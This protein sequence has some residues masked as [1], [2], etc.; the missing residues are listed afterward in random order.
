VRSTDN[1]KFLFDC[2]DHTI[3]K[4]IPAEVSYLEKFDQMK[5]WLNDNFEMPDKTVA[6]LIRFLE[7]NNGVLSNRARKHEFSA[8]K[9]NEIQLIEHHYQR[10]FT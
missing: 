10:I 3:K 4:N 9:N 2:I 7:Q 5:A 6:Q 8:L 1:I